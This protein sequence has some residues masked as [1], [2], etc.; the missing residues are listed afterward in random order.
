MDSQSALSEVE[1]NDDIGVAGESGMSG[2]VVFSLK[3]V[4]CDVDGTPTVFLWLKAVSQ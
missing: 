1:D 4:I 2:V 3:K